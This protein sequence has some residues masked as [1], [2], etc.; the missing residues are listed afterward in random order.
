MTD[1]SLD[2]MQEKKAPAL[3]FPP[4]SFLPNATLAKGLEFIL[5]YGWF[6][7]ISTKNYKYE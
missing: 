4:S 7:D 6:N 3:V 1:F 5:V 2:V